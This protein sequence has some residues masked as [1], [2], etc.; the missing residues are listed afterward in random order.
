MSLNIYTIIDWITSNNYYQHDIVSFNNKF[1]YLLPNRLLGGVISPDN[2]ITNWGGYVTDSDGTVKPKFLWIPSYGFNIP[3]KPKIKKIDFE[4]YTQRVKQV[5]NNNLLTL[6]L[7]FDERKLPEITAIAH[8]LDKR[9]ASESFCFVPPNPFGNQMRFICED[10]SMQNVSYNN[11]S[12]K[13]TF[14]QAAV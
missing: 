13:A 5:I 12:I 8:F 14:V 2:D 3:L 6:E 10:Y 9:A 1:Y 7:G 11:N 4:G